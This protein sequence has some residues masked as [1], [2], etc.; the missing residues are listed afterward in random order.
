M[1]RRLPLLL[2]ALA[3][4]AAFQLSGESAE[5]NGHVHFSGGAHFSGGFHASGGFRG[6][7][8]YARPAWGGRSYY[9]G[10]GGYYGGYRGGW[11][12]GG[13][14]WVG[15]GGYWPGYYYYRPYPYYYYY[16][17]PEAVPSY[18]PVQPE[19]P[20]VEAAAVIAPPPQ[21]PKLGVGVFAGGISVQGVDQSS[22]VGILARLRLGNGGLLVEGE[23]AKTSF[24]DD[25]RVD[26]R[27]GGSLIYEFGARNAFAPYVLAGLGVNQS[28][29]GGDYNTTQDFAEIGVGLRLALSR[30]LHLT[31]D[32]RAGSRNTV[33]SDSSPMNGGLART[34]APPPSGSNDSEDYTRA[35]LAAILM[36]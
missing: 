21:L 14:I 3:F 15:G 12:T 9:R 29:T 16:T 36:F 19:A 6:G 35:R 11:R 27:L 17:T 26:R 31:L 33:S 24:K 8:R 30:N 2:G 7:A 13:H 22:D 5:A 18:Y 20:G 1:T 25:T 28:Q 10:G 34:I 23:L 32:V 4:A